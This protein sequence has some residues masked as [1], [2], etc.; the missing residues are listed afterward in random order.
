MGIDLV[1]NDKSFGC[2]YSNWSRLRN[3]FVRAT[4]AYLE[5]LFARETYDEETREFDGKIRLLECIQIVRDRA[6]SIS[7][8]IHTDVLGYSLGE[9]L[10]DECYLESLLTTLRRDKWLGEQL[11]LFGVGGIVALCNKYDEAYSVSNGFF[12]VGNSTDICELFQKV[13]PFIQEN[14]CSE[15]VDLQDLFDVFEESVEKKR[16]VFVD[17]L[18]F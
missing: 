7:G 13:S 5:D 12:S 14:K 2:S 9:L 6:V 15:E 1:C 10:H 18:Y 11:I 3:A 16:V 4:F 17:S 8:S